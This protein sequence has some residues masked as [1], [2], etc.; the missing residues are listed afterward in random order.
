MSVPLDRLYHYLGDC[1]NHDLVI[2]RWAPHGSRKLEDLNQIKLYT[3]HETHILPILIFHDQEPLNYDFYTQDQI[4]DRAKVQ[5]VKSS[6]EF[7]LKDSVLDYVSA[8]HLRAVTICT[9]NYDLTI[10]V[11]SEQ[12][13]WQVDYF[14]QKNFLPVYYWSHAVISQDW[15]RYAAH[16]PMLNFDLKN[17]KQDFLIYNRAW[18]GTREYRL[19]FIEHLINSDLIGNCKTTFNAVDQHTHY[20]AHQFTNKKFTIQNQQLENYFSPNTYPSTASADYVG[21]DYVETGI[22]VVLETL[23]DDTRWHLT[24][25]TL[26]PIACGK[27]FILAATPGSLQYLQNYG[28]ETFADLID[29]SYDTIANSQDRLKAIIREMKRISALDADAK[30]VLYTKLHE[31]AQRNKHRFFNGLFDQV[32]E[33]YQTNLN[34]AMVV[35]QQHCTGRHRTAIRQL[36]QQN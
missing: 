13:S 30:Q 16:D 20:T 12:Q 32:I 19:C 4:C 34:Q 6:M 15:F 9:N 18:S 10:L 7:M 33:E 11:H 3:D 21:K 25:K 14:K 35:M 36:L 28:F 24:E 17:I 26:R 23:F 5:F 27:P 22:E 1:V 29:E 8:Q 2:Y 31:I